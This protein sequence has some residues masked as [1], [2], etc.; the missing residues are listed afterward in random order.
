MKPHLA[1]DYE[2]SND[3]TSYTFTLRR[4]VKFHPIAPVNAREMD[5]DDWRTTMDYFMAVGANRAIWNEIVAKAEFPDSRHMTLKLKE[6]YAPLLKRLQEYNFAPKI[7]PKELNQKP[8][9]MATN[10]IGTNYRMLDKHQPSIGWELKKWDGYWRGKPFIDRWHVAVVTETANAYAQFI[11]QN[12]VTYGPG[13]RD[14]LNLRKDAP[15][16]IMLNVS[17]TTD[18]VNRSQFGK[19]EAST[20]PWKDPRIRIGL[21]KLVNW[22]EIGELLSNRR[23]YTDAGIEADIKYATHVP[24]NPEYFLDP[25]KNELGEASKNYLYDVAEAKRLFTAAGYPDGIDLNF[26]SRTD[27]EAIKV[28]KD[29]L[30]KSGLVRMNEEI[31]T[32]LDWDNRIVYEGNFKGLAA[33]LVSGS[34]PDVDY[35]FSYNFLTGGPVTAYP[36]PK[37]D[38]IVR[39]SR[40]ELDPLKRAEIIKDF[41]RYVAN[42]FNTLPAGHRFNSWRFEWPWVHNVNHA[43]TSLNTSLN[44]FAYQNWLD[45]SMPRRNG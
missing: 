19:V 41:Q 34:G 3:G 43:S 2:I 33:S 31:V 18:V 5:I 20:S 30:K 29:E 45:P 36:N 8:D 26:V 7:T 21:H 17:P 39:A 11:A 14:A 6:P 32:A 10:M 27:T 12:I 35:L 37:I 16:A 42:T 4:G 22:D 24:W 44:N 9:I 1:D 40:R 13:A 25:R 15:N 28:H 38:D 23:A